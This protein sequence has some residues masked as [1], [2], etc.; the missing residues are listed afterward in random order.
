M[1]ASELLSDSRWVTL[2]PSQPGAPVIKS[3]APGGSPAPG[4]SP[5]PSNSPAPSAGPAEE[6]KEPWMGNRW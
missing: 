2:M 3:P 1:E 6:K 5:A 4:R